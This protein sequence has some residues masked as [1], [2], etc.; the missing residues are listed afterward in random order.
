MLFGQDGADQADDRGAVGEDTDDVDAAP[1]FAVEPLVGFVGP[2][3]SPDIAWECGEGEYFVAGGVEVGVHVGQ[4]VFDLVEQFV[5]LGV[6]GGGV[7][8][9]EH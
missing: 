9:V 2:D 3:L 5:V 8:L 6:H 1:D 4:R 7:D